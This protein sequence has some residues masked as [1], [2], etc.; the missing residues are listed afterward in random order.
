VIDA[1]GDNDFARVRIGIRD[2]QERERRKAEEFVLNPVSPKQREILQTVFAR[3]ASV[4]L[5][6]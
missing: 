4:I 2:P 6:S 1:I 3:I 5:A